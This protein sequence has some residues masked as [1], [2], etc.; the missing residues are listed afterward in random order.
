MSIVFIELFTFIFTAFTNLFITAVIRTMRTIFIR[1]IGFVIEGF[2]IHIRPEFS[3]FEVIALFT[4]LKGIMILTLTAGRIPAFLT[5][6][7]HIPT[8]TV[9]AKLPLTGAGT[10]SGTIFIITFDPV[11]AFI[12]FAKPLKDTLAALF[13]VDVIGVFDLVI[14]FQE[15]VNLNSA[16][17]TISYS[18]LIPQFGIELIAAAYTPAK[19]IFHF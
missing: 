15:V 2:A 13:A 17:G 4:N 14:R 7:I 16:P 8:G 3:F 5:F 9:S 11:A 10:Y 6:A 19:R 1:V 18:V 12:I